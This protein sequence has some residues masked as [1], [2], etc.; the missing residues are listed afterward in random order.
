MKTNN[1]NSIIVLVVYSILLCIVAVFGCV[2]AL[3]SHNQK[4]SNISYSQMQ[5]NSQEVLNKISQAESKSQVIKIA[6]D[7]GLKQKGDYLINISLS[8]EQ[9]IDNL[10]LQYVTSYGGAAFGSTDNELVV[11]F[12]SNNKQAIY[13]YYDGNNN[14]IGAKLYK[15]EL[16]N[17]NKKM[18]HV[19]DKLV[20]QLKILDGGDSDINQDTIR[21][22]AQE[23]LNLYQNR[24]LEVKE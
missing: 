15:R 21:K 6:K 23:Y 16:F 13:V 22:L 4:Q 11:Y 1:K 18:Y 8:H 10:N 17:K 20:S 3:H 24:Y 7:Y 12:V 2:F 14:V 19:N 5:N 9:I